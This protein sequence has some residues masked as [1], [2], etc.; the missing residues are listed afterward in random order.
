MTLN[1][2]TALAAACAMSLAVLVG[3]AGSDSSSQAEKVS[4]SDNSGSESLDSEAENTGFYSGEHKDMGWQ[5]G[6]V[7]IVGG[8]FVPNVVYNPSGAYAPPPRQLIGDF[9]GRQ[10][11]AL[12]KNE[13]PTS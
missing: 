4:G 8:G 9:Q 6:N 5:W 10:A 12:R 2:L 7:E 13:P 1:K 11:P 3:C